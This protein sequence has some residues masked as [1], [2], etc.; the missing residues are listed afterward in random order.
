M[1]YINKFKLLER[2]A[3]YLQKISSVAT[4]EWYYNAA[5]YKSEKIELIALKEFSKNFLKTYD[6]ISNRSKAVNELLKD[7]QKVIPELF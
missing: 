6:K 2:E 7:T 5:S 4:L 1:Q 3:K